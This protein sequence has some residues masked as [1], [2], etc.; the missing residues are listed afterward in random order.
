MGIALGAPQQR[1]IQPHNRVATGRAPGADRLDLFAAFGLGAAASG[2]CR[3][4]AVQR[5]L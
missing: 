3:A 2:A 5:V 1:G 4:Q